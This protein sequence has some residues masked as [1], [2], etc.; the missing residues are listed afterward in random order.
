M[1]NYVTLDGKKYKTQNANWVETEVN[2]R[3]VAR[4]AS[5]RGDV[6]FVSSAY[7]VWVGTLVAPISAASG[8]G[9]KADLAAAF[10][11]KTK[12]AYE[13]HLGAAYEVAIGSK[14]EK[15][16]QLPDWDNAEN[17]FYIYM[18]IVSL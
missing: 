1:R 15:R 14:M 2:A 9:T 3:Q 7:F 10:R 13:D 11:K 8:W 6:T 5:G 16:S 4:L 12:L 17:A 18:E